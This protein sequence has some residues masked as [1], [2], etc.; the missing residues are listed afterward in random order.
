[1]FYYSDDC[2]DFVETVIGYSFHPASVSVLRTK[3]LYISDSQ[4]VTNSQ[5]LQTSGAEYTE[6]VVKYYIILNATVTSGYFLLSTAKIA[7]K[8]SCLSAW[9]TNGVLPEREAQPNQNKG[10]EAWAGKAPT[11]T[12][13]LPSL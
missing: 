3:D 2:R 11:P 4:K 10:E 1:M 5:Y 12:P 9:L 6:F 13:A 8:L 7:G